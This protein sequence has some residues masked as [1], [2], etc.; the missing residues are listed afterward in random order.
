MSDV[1]KNTSDYNET[2]FNKDLIEKAFSKA[3]S[4]YD[5]AAAFQRQV[6]HRLLDKIDLAFIA[7]QSRWCVYKVMLRIYRLQRINLI[8]DFQT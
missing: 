4:N 7:A 5:Q 6:G 3:A 8:L 1:I 2:L